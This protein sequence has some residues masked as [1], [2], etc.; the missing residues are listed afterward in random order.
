M[1]T[2]KSSNAVT[3]MPQINTYPIKIGNDSHWDVTLLIHFGTQEYISAQV[4]NAA[5]ANVTMSARL[6]KQSC[7]KNDLKSFL[8][9]TGMVVNKCTRFQT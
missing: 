3:D 6:S 8:G 2:A 7:Q 4:F 9:Q 1:M 5:Q